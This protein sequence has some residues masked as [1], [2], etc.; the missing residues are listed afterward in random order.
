MKAAC[1]LI[2]GILGLVIVV[3]ETKKRYIKAIFEA[4]LC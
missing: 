1:K 3:Y 2:L 4:K